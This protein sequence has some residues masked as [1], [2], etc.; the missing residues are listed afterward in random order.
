MWHPLVKPLV[1]FNRSIRWVAT[2]N[3]AFVVA[4]IW[5]AAK[6]GRGASFYVPVIFLGLF[7]LVWLRDFLFGFRVKLVSDGGMLQWQEG[8]EL[9]SVPLTEIQKILIGARP[10]AHGGGYSA[11]EVRLQLKTGPELELPPNLASGLRARNWRHL[12]RLV[13]HIRTV[14]NIKVELVDEPGMTADGWE[15][16]VND[17]TK[18]NSLR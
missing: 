3:L 10:P 8:T 6:Y 9:G 16:E 4:G 11:T 7:S 13:A 12:K 15:D 1:F 18:A 5:L 14:S 17:T 2:L